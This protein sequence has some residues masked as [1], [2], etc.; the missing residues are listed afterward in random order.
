MTIFNNYTYLYVED[1]QMSRQVM[2][3]LMQT[4]M[5]VEKFTTFADSENFVTRLKALDPKPDVILLDIHV[6]PMD[7]FQMLE[8]IKADTDYAETK[9]IALT[10]SV[11][12]EE[13]TKLRTSGFD[14]AISKPVSIQSFPD[15][16]KRVLDGD[17]VWHVG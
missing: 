9:V 11:M 10:A 1:D 15:L 7:G 2:T 12:N 4:G 13:I 3:M 17:V 8:V 16:I 5:G 6:P 14:G